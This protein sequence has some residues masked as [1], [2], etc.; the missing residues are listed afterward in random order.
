M[1]DP[2]NKASKTNA[3]PTTNIDYAVRKN[4]SWSVSSTE[5]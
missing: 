5:K 3:K 4:D 2:H 1:Q